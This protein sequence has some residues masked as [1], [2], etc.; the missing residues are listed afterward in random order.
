M[1]YFK[2]LL[3]IGVM[4]GGIV[5]GAV[6]VP[7]NAASNVFLFQAADESYVYY[8]NTGY[9]VY[10]FAGYGHA[11]IEKYVLPKGLT[12]K[13][14]KSINGKTF[15]GV[16]LKSQDSLGGKKK[17]IKWQKNWA[18]I[19]INKTNE[20]DVNAVFPSGSS[21][22]K[23]HDYI[24]NTKMDNIFA[25]AKRTWKSSNEAYINYELIFK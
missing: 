16:I 10:A 17:P 5:G 7:S 22:G 13:T 1:K 20:L 12:T 9:L 11:V 8:S 4:L 19:N 3:I 6:E 2:I 23:Y 25:K 14:V 15:P 24:N 21:G 18:N